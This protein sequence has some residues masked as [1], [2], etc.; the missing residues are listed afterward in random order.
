M[1]ISAIR[2]AR[3]RVSTVAARAPRRLRATHPN[4]AEAATIAATTATTRR[5]EALRAAQEIRLEARPQRAAEQALAR[6]QTRR[7]ASPTGRSRPRSAGS[8]P[9]AS[10]AR[11]HWAARSHCATAPPAAVAAISSAK[12]SR[13]ERRGPRDVAVDAVQ[14]EQRVRRRHDADH[15][16]DTQALRRRDR[17]HARAEAMTDGRS[18][19]DLLTDALVRGQSAVA[20]QLAQAAG[21]VAQ[22]LCARHGADPRAPG[23]ED[24]S[25]LQHHPKLGASWEGFAVEP[26]LATEPHTRL[27][28]RASGHQGAEID[29]LLHHR[30]ELFGVEC[31]PSDGPR[32][33]P[34]MRIALADLGLER[35]AVIYPGSRRYAVADRVEAVPLATLAEPGRLFGK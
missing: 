2:P 1:H 14:A 33:T 26:V 21:Q 6:V 18:Y 4:S 13:A 10:R 17:R 27:P 23:I 16:D 30:G 5:D 11:R 35:V 22:G 20:R 25:A 15:D 9:R 12:P 34:S 28:G 29:L 31:R 8:P 19:L 7:R 3:C 24:H 32:M